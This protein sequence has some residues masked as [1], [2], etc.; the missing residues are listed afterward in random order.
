[1]SFF[2]DLKDIYTVILRKREEQT[3]SFDLTGYR[4]ISSLDLISASGLVNYFGK[5]TDLT[6]VEISPL[7]MRKG[8][9]RLALYGL[10][11]L[12]DERL[13]RLFMDY[14]VSSVIIQIFSVYM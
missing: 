8:A 14:K 6:Q 2:F 3:F 7:L 4:Q 10:S 9:T 13:A 5:W 1:M 12:K 11:H